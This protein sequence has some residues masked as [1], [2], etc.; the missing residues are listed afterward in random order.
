MPLRP[1]LLAVAARE[2]RWIL[3]DPAARFLLFGVPVIAFA[4][5]GFTF[6]SAVVRGLD[7]I[8]VDMDNTAT[9]RLFIQTVAAAPGI[10]VAERG[11]DLGAAASAIRAGR[12]IAAIF[13]PPEFGKDLLA[14]RAPRPVVFTNTQ[15]FTPGNNAGKSIGDAMAAAS[16]AVAPA[17]QA[18]GDRTTPRPGL[19]P[20]EY[21]LSNPALNYAQFLLRAVLPTVLHVVIAI[22]AGYSVGSEF[23]RRSMR[24]WWDLSG[25]NI[26]AALVGK[27]LPYFVVLMLMFVLIIGILDVWLG[28]SF[29]GS[30]VLTAVSATLLIVSYQM[31][32]CLMQLLARNMA[33]GLS[34]T[35]II[36]SPAFGFAGVGFP[37][38]GME[39]FARAWGAI[40]PLR[41]YIQILFDQATRGAAL[42]FTAEPFAIL[43]GITVVL[44]LLVWLRFRWL[45]RHGVTL[46]E[47]IDPVIE[48]ATPG[49]AG[50]F[51]AEWRR[52]LADRGVFA[53]FV[54]APVLYA[55]FY[56]RPYLG[57]I[58]RRILIAVVDQDRS[59]LG[60]ALIQA[61]EAHD[62]ISV[63]L[64]AS[65]YREA[66]DAILARRAFAIVGI[67]PDTEKNVL[68][69]VTARLPVYADSTYFILFN[70]SLQGILESV[71]AYATDVL[72]HGARPEGAGVQAA[73]RLNQPVELVQVP[74]FNPTASYAS[75]VVPAA[76]VLILHQT[77]LMGA[78]MLGGVAF[79]RGGSAARR[80]RASSAAILGQGLA[81]WTLYIPAM[82]LYFVVMPR[83][84]G[85]STL[86]S[87]SA[88][89]ALSVPFILATSFLGQALGLV[90]RHRET[91]VLLVLASSLPQ[92]F[93]V[94]VSWPAEALPGFLRQARE[95]LP[96]VN[97]IDGIVRVNQMGASLAEVRPDWMR[98]WAL[99]L[100][101][102]A[103]AVAIAHLRG[104]RAPGD[105]HAV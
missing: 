72:T 6:S 88:L 37:V 29:R 17:R 73:S 71:Q 104:I 63:A 103:V 57:Q 45:A 22:S 39:S 47:D 82:L 41:W 24:E 100:L 25:H 20:E 28:V 42:N 26:A 85:F 56:P 102:F 92:F 13:L 86:G 18:V 34:L 48:P 78:A 77:L 75:Y 10:T 68:K 91:A 89:A 53:L 62:N 90:F 83:V 79:E 52:A 74:L 94:G 3:G 81:H 14:G 15:F 21:V 50:A 30:A 87:F 4:V 61:L 2:V 33:V 7:V 67:P 12:A 38:L 54:L 65:S 70:R 64:R 58:V 35:G 40:L 8:A 84:Y 46:P 55:F 9:S 95:L 23:R 69:G 76:F 99:T 27:L 51:M 36:V 5:L 80:A 32:G 16:A 97:A 19:V 66:E 101:Y 98:L 1:G 93:L 43:C 105:A 31:I 59:E 96:S 60:R 49:V 44:A 11:N